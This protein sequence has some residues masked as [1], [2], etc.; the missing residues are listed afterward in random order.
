MK[1]S[2]LIQLLSLYPQDAD[3]S[4]IGLEHFY[5]YHYK[6]FVK[7]QD[8]ILLESQ[9]LDAS[10]IEKTDITQIVSFLDTK[11]ISANVDHVP[12]DDDDRYQ[13]AKA[14]LSSLD[15]GKYND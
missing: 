13:I 10:D 5:F 9:I 11:T 8:I 15:T 14:I 7:N 6:D 2:T 3:V 12:I 4:L 1:V